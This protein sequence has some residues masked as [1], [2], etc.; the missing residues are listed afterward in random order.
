[1][2]TFVLLR[3]L[4]NENNQHFNIFECSHIHTCG[5]VLHRFTSPLQFS[6]IFKL[7]EWK[8]NI[9]KS[10]VNPHWSSYIF[11]IGRYISSVSLW[12][13]DFFWGHKNNVEVTIIFLKHIVKTTSYYD[14]MLF[15]VSQTYMI[16]SCAEVKLFVNH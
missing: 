11:N 6:A 2:I 15:F 8:K 5:V 3:M 13:S 10:F 14:I 12:N 7:Q 1:M 16:P 9:Y 4:S